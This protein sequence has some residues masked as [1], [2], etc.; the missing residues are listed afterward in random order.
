MKEIRG[1]FDE[2]GQIVVYM[3][4]GGCYNEFEN[5]QA[6]AKTINKPVIDNHSILD[7]LWRIN[8]L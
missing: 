8:S 7:I 3:A 6:L 4:D 1:V 5:L 2:Y